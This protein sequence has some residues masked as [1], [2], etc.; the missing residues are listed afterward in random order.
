MTSSLQTDST[1]T[2][3]AAVQPGSYVRR[4]FLT[5]FIKFPQQFYEFTL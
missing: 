1:S 5:E 2:A 3:W 4:K